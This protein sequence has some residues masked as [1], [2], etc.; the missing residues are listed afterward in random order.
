LTLKII[1]EGKVL[2]EVGTILLLP[3][4]NYDTVPL[5]L[6]GSD[7]VTL[8]GVRST[9]L[10]CT[11]KTV[12]NFLEVIE[13]QY[14]EANP[15]HNAAHAAQVAHA[16]VCLHR[17]LGLHDR[18]TPLDSVALIVAALTH[19]VNHP[20]YTNS[21]MV[22]TRSTLAIVYNDMS[23]LENHH[24]SSTF[25]A[26]QKADCNILE[27]IPTE[28]WF[29]LR[30]KIIELILVTDMKE[31]F[32]RISHLRVRR[33]AADFDHVA[34][35]EDSW[36]VTKMCLKAGDLS[37][38]ALEWHQHYKWSMCLTEEFYRQG[39]EE[40]RLGMPTS[41]LCN[42]MDNSRLSTYQNGFLNFVVLPLFTELQAID[43]TGS[44]DKYCVERIRSNDRT[45]G[46]VVPELPNSKPRQN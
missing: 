23:V 26:M 36:L 34:S 11:K 7:G 19:D 27:G 21:F 3:Y 41:P 44:V 2:S 17:L 10:V 15:Y 5:N 33:A 42:R 16:T 35:E 20:G 12:R 1:A 37:H 28:N 46:S 22:N 40:A 31:H 14:V 24:A 13:S 45:W 4:I 43:E 30:R 25:L 32:D 29:Q 18:M 6:F 8:A 39:D 9:S 38:A